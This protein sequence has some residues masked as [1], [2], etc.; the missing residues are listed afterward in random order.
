MPKV[1]LF[2]VPNTATH[3]F[4]PQKMMDRFYASAPGEDWTIQHYETGWGGGPVGAGLA[5]G[6]RIF[7]WP[8]GYGGIAEWAIDAITGAGGVLVCA[9]RDFDFNRYDYPAR[10]PWPVLIATPVN[11]AGGRVA[12]T[13][14]YGPGVTVGVEVNDFAV[15]GPSW[16]VASAAA[17]LTRYPEAA[18]NPQAAALRM[19]AGSEPIGGARWDEYRGFGVVKT[20]HHALVGG[21]IRIADAPTNNINYGLAG[22]IVAVPGG[23]RYTGTSTHNS[24]VAYRA[25]P[26]PGAGNGARW[27]FSAANHHPAQAVRLRSQFGGGFV[28]LEPGESGAYTI[29]SFSSSAALFIETTEGVGGE[30]DVTITGLTQNVYQHVTSMSALA[31]VGAVLSPILSVAET[32]TPGKVSV[33]VTR[34]G[35]VGASVRVDGVERMQT[36]G[37]SAKLYLPSGVSTIEARALLA[38]GGVT[39]AH[40]PGTLALDVPLGYVPP[41]PALEVQRTIYG[42]L[43]DAQ[44]EGATGYVVT[45]QAGAEPPT[46]VEG[47]EVVWPA[48]LPARVVA[49]AVGAGG[50]S[51]VTVTCVPAVRSAAPLVEEGLHPLVMSV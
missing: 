5:D 24:L 49:T 18:A 10:P 37:T 8:V 27:T 36:A 12:M 28:V 21:P 1:A 47:G 11:V 46:E 30:V 51:G 50:T 6:C 22:S 26:G 3:D 16:G 44:A 2:D 20:F 48:H 23:Y 7:A 31:P 17:I 13:T 19:I 14:T 42:L 39:E 9:V 40:Q 38:G 34:L 45:V 32:A 25:M 35:G 29:E 4:H 15:G 33:S 43:V 41:A